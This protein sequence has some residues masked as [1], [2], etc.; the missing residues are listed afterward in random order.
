MD[1]RLACFHLIGDPYTSAHRSTRQSHS[2][3]A[4]TVKLGTERLLGVNSVVSRF[5]DSRAG[6]CMRRTSLNSPSTLIYSDSRTE[7]HCAASS[8]LTVDYHHHPTS[9]TPSRHHERFSTSVSALV[10]WCEFQSIAWAWHST[11]DARSNGPKRFSYASASCQTC[12]SVF[13]DEQLVC[14]THDVCRDWW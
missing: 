7:P 9:N 3:L 12:V 14:D 4:V 13:A 11:V 1:S 2:H 10:R 8:P 5:M 6:D